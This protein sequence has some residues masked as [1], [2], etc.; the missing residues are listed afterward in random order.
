VVMVVVKEE[1]EG[2]EEEEER[3]LCRRKGVKEGLC[4]EGGREAKDIE[5]TTGLGR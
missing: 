2:E 3:R 1:E 5:R 4:T